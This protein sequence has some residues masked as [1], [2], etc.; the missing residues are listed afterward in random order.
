MADEPLVLEHSVEADVSQA[1]AW[2]F[3]TDIETWDDPPATFRLDG[4]FTDGA[5]GTT[6][7]PGQEP[8][9]WWIR[10]VHPDHSFAIEI[11]LDGATLRCEWYLDP[12]AERR[13]KLTQRLILSGSNADTYRQQVET[14]FGA[15]LETG[16]KKIAESMVVA[17]RNTTVTD[18]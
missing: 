3:R 2:R 14:G 17:E 11:P 13:T 16:M 18:H 5:R 10:A 1:F 6:L 9:T 4:P 8:L 12:V 15:S 7:M